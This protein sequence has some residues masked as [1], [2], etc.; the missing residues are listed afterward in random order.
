VIV[1]INCITDFKVVEVHLNGKA[2]GKRG[3]WGGEIK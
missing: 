1:G 2:R 3:I